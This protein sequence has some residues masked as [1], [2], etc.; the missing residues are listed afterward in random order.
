MDDLKK[1][2]FLAASTPFSV[3]DVVECRTVGVLYDGIG[4]VRSISFNPKDFGSPVYP[5]FRVEL[6]E[7][8]DELV[9]DVVTYTEMC[10]TKVDD[11]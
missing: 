7:K 8:S 9:P 2:L 6:T 3:G 10:L 5:S 11:A 1:W 4:I